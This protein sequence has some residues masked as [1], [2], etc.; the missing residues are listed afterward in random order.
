MRNFILF[1]TIV[2]S[3]LFW[4]CSDDDTEPGTCD[5]QTIVD[6]TRFDIATDADL[7]IDSL[8]VDGDCLH[9]FY[10]ASGC[11]AESWEL[12]L[13]DSGSI[14]ES[15]P[16]QRSLRFEFKNTESCL[17]YF[18]K[19]LSFDLSELQVSKNEVILNISGGGTNESISYT[20]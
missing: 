17:A 9:V 19:E 15:L 11:D 20:Y 7:R 10:S 2:S 14:D 6:A 8:S 18:S 13:I 3:L 5:K 16:E 4:S 1:C 12:E